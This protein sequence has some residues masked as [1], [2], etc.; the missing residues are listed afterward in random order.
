MHTSLNAQ[1]APGTSELSYVT[2]ISREDIH[3]WIVYMLSQSTG[4]DSQDIDVTLPCT[5]YGLDSLTGVTLVGDLELWLNVS[6]SPTLLWEMPSIDRLVQYLADELAVMS[7]APVGAHELDPACA[8]GIK[9]GP[10]MAR[11]LLLQLEQ[12]SDQDVEA[13]L[14]ELAA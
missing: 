9:L 7:E 4:L 8:S 5:A 13:M 14:N 6:L 10:E 3:H 11:R 1:A 12:L 2:A